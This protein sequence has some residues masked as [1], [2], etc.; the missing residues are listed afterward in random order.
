MAQEARYLGVT[1]VKQS[2][3]LFGAVLIVVCT[4]V[5]TVPASAH[6]VF[7]KQ[8]AAK[9]PDR[10]ISCTTCMARARKLGMSMVAF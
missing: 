3:S 2:K 6:S 9:Y 1:N 8:L 10:S 4:L 5:F 7:K